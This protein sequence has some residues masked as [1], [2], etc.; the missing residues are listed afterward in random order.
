MRDTFHMVDGGQFTPKR[1]NQN[2]AMSKVRP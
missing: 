2:K 1:P